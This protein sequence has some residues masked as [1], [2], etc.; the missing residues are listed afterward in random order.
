MAGMMTPW[1]PASPLDD[2]EFSHVRRRAI[3]DCCKWDPQVGDS[4][5]IARSPLVIQRDEWNHVVNLAEALA[6]ETL[7]AEAEVVERPALHRV[8]GLPRDVRRA[9]TLVPSI[10]PS[11]GAARLIRFDFH[12]TNDGWRISEA[13]CDVPGGLNE[14][15]GFPPLFAASHSWAT[16]VGDPVAGYVDAL[17]ARVGPGGRVAFVH[18]TA[19]SDDQQMMQFVARR[20]EKAG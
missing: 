3:F 18:A 20:L 5:S 19:Y 13:N 11:G 6:R 15:S 9:L 1:I 7:A 4:C 8:L 12:F 17:A 2:R 16:P 10:G 14:A